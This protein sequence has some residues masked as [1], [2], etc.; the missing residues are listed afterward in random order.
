MTIELN[1]SPHRHYQNLGMKAQC[2][3]SIKFG[4]HDDYASMLSHTL[5]RGHLP[6]HFLTEPGELPSERPYCSTTNRPPAN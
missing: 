1:Q 6:F 3:A 2:R 4:S 5:Q